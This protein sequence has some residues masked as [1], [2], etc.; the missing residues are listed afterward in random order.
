LEFR[1][2][3]V[4]EV[5]EQAARIAQNPKTLQK[6]QVPAMRAV[7]FKMG[8]IMRERMNTKVVTKRCVA[9]ATSE[10]PALRAIRSEKTNRHGLIR[11]LY[12]L[13]AGVSVI[14]AALFRSYN[15][16]VTFLCVEGL[17]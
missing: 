11:E 13:F 4:F 16:S 2:F 15:D 8:R 1:D 6:I 14:A 17:T 12:T 9:L 3:A 5:R 10:R 7:K